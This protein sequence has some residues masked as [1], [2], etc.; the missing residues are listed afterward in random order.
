M[1][2]IIDLSGQTFG[3]ITVVKLNRCEN[4]ITYWECFC[5]CN[6][7]RT[8][9]FDW[10]RIKDRKLPNC[11]C[12]N[13]TW[14]R[15]NEYNLDGDF[16][17]GYI[18]DIEFYF[19]LEDYDK[20]KNRYWGLD[21]KGYLKSR[22][23]GKGMFIHRF[24]MDC[25]RNMVVD[26]IDMNPLNNRKSNLRIATRRENA[27]NREKKPNFSSKYIGVAFKK[28][29]QKWRAQIYDNEGKNIWI[30]QYSNEEDAARAY[31]KKAIEFGY[32]SH[33]IIEENK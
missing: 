9:E 14:K 30:G 19:D 4:G 16:G 18:N 1:Q 27:Q 11:G 32:L 15:N 31:N 26:H 10:S 12:A 28:S 5:D 17:I 21:H 23:G 20:I 3:K 7:E 29:S 8:F 13:K 2:K 22:I 24:I 33:N 6:P 25:P